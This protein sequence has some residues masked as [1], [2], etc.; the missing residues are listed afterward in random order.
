MLNS[1][2]FITFQNLSAM[3]E[4][5]ALIKNLLNEKHCSCPE[6]LPGLKIK[7]NVTCK[8]QLYLKLQFI[9]SLATV[10]AFL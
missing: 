7:H 2:C 10:Y 5:K 8:N 6:I 9:F 4:S 1:K 3:P